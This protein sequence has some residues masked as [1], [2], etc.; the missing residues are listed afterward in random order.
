MVAAAILA[1]RPA[2]DP[3]RVAALH[4]CLARRIDAS[5]RTPRMAGRLALAAGRVPPEALTGMRARAL[6]GLAA[7]QGVVPEDWRD[8]LRDA[9]CGRGGGEAAG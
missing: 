1:A 3:R 8:A 5:A 7:L 6:L 2:A 9:L 4:R